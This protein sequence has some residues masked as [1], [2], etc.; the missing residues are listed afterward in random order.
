MSIVS[1]GE[2][3]LLHL[4]LRCIRRCNRGAE[5]SQQCGS[6][7]TTSGR[8]NNVLSTVARSSCSVPRRQ[9]RTS[10]PSEHMKTGSPRERRRQS[11]H[12]LAKFLVPTFSAFCT[13]PSLSV[14]P[15][16]RRLL[17]A[18]HLA[19]DCTALVSPAPESTIHSRPAVASQ[20]EMEAGA[21]RLRRWGVRKGGVAATSPLGRRRRL[22]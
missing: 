22:S 4:L 8:G 19:V 9:R 12:I 17:L 7:T 6:G 15:V 5:T 3:P 13:K 16:R 10:R 18:S 14:G 1:R 11:R 2:Q 21:S 20:E